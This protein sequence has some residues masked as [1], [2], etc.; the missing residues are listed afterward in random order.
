MEQT[1]VAVKHG[2]L[3]K[4]SAALCGI[5]RNTLR[6]CINARKHKKNIGCPPFLSSAKDTELFH[7]I[8]W[9]AEVR[10]LITGKLLRRSVYTYCK[11]N[12]IM[13]NFNHNSALAGRKWMKLFMRWHPHVSKR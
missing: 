3:L 10:T 11:L 8:F 2:T 9:L 1:V 13:N 6:Y 4:T 12:R 7:Q 5:A